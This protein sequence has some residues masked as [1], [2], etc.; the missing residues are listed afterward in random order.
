MSTI[1]KSCRILGRGVLLENSSFWSSV[2]VKRARAKLFFE[3]L[4]DFEE[5]SRFAD[6]NCL[7]NSGISLK[8]LIMEND[9]YIPTTR[10][11]IYLG[12]HLVLRNLNLGMKLEKV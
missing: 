7:T 2:I 4:S 10:I 12:N 9:R 6:E 8:I 1:N 5:A 3:E 11:P